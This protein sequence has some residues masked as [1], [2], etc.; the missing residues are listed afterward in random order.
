MITEKEQCIAG[1][2]DK[3]LQSEVEPG[4]YSIAGSIPFDGIFM[5]KEENKWIV[6]DVSRGRIYRHLGEF[7]EIFLASLFCINMLIPYN[8]S[9]EIQKKFCEILHKNV[10][11]FNDY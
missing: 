10:P 8:K 9:G 11:G 5:Y 7:Q 4:G 6:A 2:L 3:I 1:E